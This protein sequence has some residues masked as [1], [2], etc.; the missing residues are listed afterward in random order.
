MKRVISMLVVLTL[1]LSLAIPVLATDF[2]PSITGKDSPDI[3]PV[4]DENGNKVQGEI[5]D[6]NGNV[7][8]Y[9]DEKCLVITPIS[10]AETSEEIP[11]HAEDLLLSVYRQL[12]NG[13][14]KLAVEKYNQG[15]NADDMVIRDLFDVTWLCEEHPEIVEPAGVYVRLTFN[16]GVDKNTDIYCMS[17]KHNDWQVIPLVNNGDG[18]VTCTFE[19]F[20]PVAFAVKSGT[21]TPPSQTGDDANLGLW[22]GLMSVSVVA[23]AAVLVFSRRKA[24]R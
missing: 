15:L 14:M 10:E 2:V 17:Y 7:I 18:T 20:C 4:T 23:L 16:L 11:D 6:A 8:G 24:A 12:K 3:V 13:T 1:C 5:V 21:D 22:I 9:L 19:D